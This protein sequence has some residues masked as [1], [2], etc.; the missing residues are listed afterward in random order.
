MGS[1]LWSGI[2]MRNDRDEMIRKSCNIT[3]LLD[4][5]P[6]EKKPFLHCYSDPGLVPFSNQ[7]SEGGGLIEMGCYKLCVEVVDD[8][9]VDGRWNRRKWNGG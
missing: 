5:F 6:P 4:S 7:K 9:I 8:T 2:K 3:P 1:I